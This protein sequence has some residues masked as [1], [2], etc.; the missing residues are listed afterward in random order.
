MKKSSFFFGAIALSVLVV[1]CSDKPNFEYYY[2]DEKDYEMM[3]RTL[4][5]PQ[6]PAKYT[7]N[8]PKHLLNGGLSSP[9]IEDAEAILGRVLFY[10]KNLSSDKTIS[11]ASCHRQE[12][13][14]A[15]DRKVSLGVESREGTRNSIALSSVASFV[16]Y[17]GSDING[18]SGI[19]FF[20]DN[21]AATAS[22]Q[23]IGSMTNPLE[24]NMKEHEIVD[25]V[26][27]QE[28]YGP[29]FEKAF[30]TKEITADLVSKAIASFVNAMG[31][32]QSRFDDAAN[33][34]NADYW[35]D[36]EADFAKFNLSENR[37]KA[38][39]NQNCASCHTTSF[40]RPQLFLANNGLDAEFTDKGVGAISGHESEKGT[41]KVP[42]LRNI[43]ITAPYMHDGRFATLEQVVD[44]YSTG[45]KYSST[46]SQQLSLGNAPKK[47]N[48]TATQKE[49]LVAFLSTLTD[50][51]FRADK[52]FSN[53]FK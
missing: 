47:F 17:Y 50:D 13:G 38:I 53:P 3:S 21:R 39:Y 9:P 7:A 43:A 20:W 1:S 33:S 41:F 15:D 10:D 4:D 12:I 25:A 22:A 24:M 27:A 30:D 23:N 8:L 51:V 48:F 29:L 44:H 31:S 5:L 40:G 6:E 32:Y 42:T 14:F 49:D 11:C 52:R 37:G 28:Y 45:I 35:T 18:P 36:Y 2:Y 46:L 19:P 34:S 16:A 26:R